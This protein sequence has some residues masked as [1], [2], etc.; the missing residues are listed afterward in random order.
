MQAAINTVADLK[1]LK[2]VRVKRVIDGL[3]TVDDIPKIR[4]S[5][6]DD[7]IDFIEDDSGF[8]YNDKY[9][10]KPKLCN[11]SGYINFRSKDYTFDNDN[12]VT[13]YGDTITRDML[14]SYGFALSVGTGEIQYHIEDL[15]IEGD[16][17]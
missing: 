9:C 15:S 3:M 11:A 14:R 4:Q 6:V 2:R 17:K 12:G 7:G 1:R 5:L 10:F 13:S 16:N 8:S